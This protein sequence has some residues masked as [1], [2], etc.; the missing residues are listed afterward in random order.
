MQREEILGY[1]KRMVT[2]GVLDCEISDS[3]IIE[4]IKDAYKKYVPYIGDTK[5]VTVIAADRVDLR[6]YNFY[7]ILNVKKKAQATY[8]GNQFD[9]ENVMKISSLRGFDLVTGILNNHNAQ[10]DT[11]DFSFQNGILFLDMDDVGFSQV[12]VEGI[13]NVEMEQIKDYRAEDWVRRYALA[14]TK[15]VLGRV[16]SKFKPQGVPVELDGDTLLSEGREEK[17]R[18]EQELSDQVIGAINITR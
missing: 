17:E 5:S 13:P 8:G 12:T 1:I 18:L 11:V 3:V 7:D 2:G 6:E 16:R 10:D 4:L 9:F 15:E 14:L